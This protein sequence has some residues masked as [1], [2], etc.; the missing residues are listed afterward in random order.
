MAAEILAEQT[1]PEQESFDQFVIRTGKDGDEAL[2]AYG[3]QLMTLRKEIAAHLGTTVAKLH[4]PFLH[5]QS[6]DQ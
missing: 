4:N 5:E 2:R 6:T 3:E 1:V